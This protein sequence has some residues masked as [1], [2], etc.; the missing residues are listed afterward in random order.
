MRTLAAAAAC[1]RE[2]AWQL[3]GFTKPLYLNAGQLAALE[4]IRPWHPLSLT[5]IEGDVMGQRLAGDFGRTRHLTQATLQ[6]VKQ[7]YPAG[8]ELSLNWADQ[9]A[10]DLRLAGFFVPARGLDETAGYRGRPGSRHDRKAA[11]AL[12]LDLSGAGAHVDALALLREARAGLEDL[13]ERLNEEILAVR[14]ACAVELRWTAALAE[15]RKLAAGVVIDGQEILGPRHLTT[16]IATAHLAQCLRL[17]RRPQDG[18][19]LGAQTLDGFRA[20]LGPG[21]P[22]TLAVQ[23]GTAVLSRAAGQLRSAAALEARA[24]TALR[25]SLGDEHPFTLCCLAGQACQRAAE[26]KQPAARKLWAKAEGRLC[27]IVGSW[28]PLHA[29]DRSEPLPGERR[30]AGRAGRRT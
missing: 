20:V 15:A 17:D 22:Y 14:H 25:G 26:G 13:G 1:A 5:A 28:A 2:A 3:G 19:Q 4:A 29:A 7:A 27:C 8:H 16:L 11:V 10:I 9:A 21:H 30:T 6:I 23:A 12:A 18:L 24:L